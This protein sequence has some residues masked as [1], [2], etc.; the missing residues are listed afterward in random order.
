MA[1]SAPPGGRGTAGDAPQ[2]GAEGQTILLA[3]ETVA[4]RSLPPP[5]ATGTRPQRCKVMMASKEADGAQPMP[6]ACR[7]PAGAAAGSAAV[8]G[9]DTPLTA[10]GAPRRT[11][12]RSANSTAAEA[13]QPAAPQ[14]V[15]I[16]RSSLSL[17]SLT[18]MAS[19][20]P[21]ASRAAQRFLEARAYTRMYASMATVVPVCE[22]AR[23]GEEPSV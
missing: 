16:A 4:A 2:G 18:A 1:S 20:T 13:H 22:C 23:D 10:A 3:A 5:V 6:A 11:K 8:S 9:P 19:R 14:D 7:R 12:R 15:R 17:V 21:A